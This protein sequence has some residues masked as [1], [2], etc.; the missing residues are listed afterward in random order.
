MQPDATTI[1]NLNIF[2]FLN[3]KSVLDSLKAELTTY[4][5]KSA[6]VDPNLAVSNGGNRMKVLS[7]VGQL[8]LARSFLCSLHQQLQNMF[9]SLLNASFNE[10][11]HHSLQDYLETSIM[12][13]YVAGSEKRGNF[14]NY[15]LKR[16]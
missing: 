4:L 12:L 14:A 10:Q 1:D 13:Q 5:A 7:H 15:G 9:F 3:S 8:L 11:Q 2:P 16:L 6:D